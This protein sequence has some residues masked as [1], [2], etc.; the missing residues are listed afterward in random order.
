M[1]KQPP[2]DVKNKQMN[3]VKNK[4][5]NLLCIVAF[6]PLISTPLPF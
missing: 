2:V 1:A 3:S 5:H 6:F 4:M